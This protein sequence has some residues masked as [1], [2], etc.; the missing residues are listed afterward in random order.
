M[1][2]KCLTE[3]GAF[4]LRLEETQRPSSGDIWRQ[5]LPTGRGT[6][7]FK[8]PE[9]AVWGAFSGMSG[10]FCEGGGSGGVEWEGY[11]KSE[12][13]ALQGGSQ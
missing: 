2:R 10:R 11:M 9:P 6:G 7:K 1:I 13:Q 5:T 12:T 8:G 3:K 4:E